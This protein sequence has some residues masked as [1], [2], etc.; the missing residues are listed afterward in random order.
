MNVLIKSACIRGSPPVRLTEWQPSV[1]GLTSRHNCFR[2]YS[3]NSRFPSP[4]ESGVS[5]QTQCMWHWKKRTKTWRTHA[6]G[7]SSWM[8][9]NISE[10]LAVILNELSALSYQSS[11]K[12]FADG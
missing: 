2:V 8:D 1:S 9:A 12:T 11:V 3:L 6:Y 5:H 4:I 7:P 10:N